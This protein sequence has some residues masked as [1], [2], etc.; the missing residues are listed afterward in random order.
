MATWRI[1]SSSKT[2]SREQIISALQVSLTPTDK[3]LAEH[4]PT[5]SVEAY[6]FFLKG[7]ANFYRYT[8]EHLLEARKCLEKAIEIDPNFADAYGYLSYCHFFG[9]SQVS[10]DFDDNLDRANELA[11]EGVALEG[12]SAI[13]LTRLGWIQAFL[14]RYDQAVANLEYAIVLAP[15]NG[16][17]NATFGQ[18]L[19][20][21]GKPGTRAAVAGKSV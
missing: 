6:D 19:N 18:V 20:Y 15:N 1:F 4:K 5:G 17:V 21:W 8:P 14:R 3:A 12:T 9:W 16:D 11:E 7:R 10:P 2:I 13:A